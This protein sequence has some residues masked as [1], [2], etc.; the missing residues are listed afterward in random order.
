MKKEYVT[1]FPGRRDSYQVPLALHESGRL[2][3]FVTN[4]YDAGP[5]AR[6]IKTCGVSRLEQRYCA[7][8]PAHRVQPG[9]DLEIGARMLGKVM[10]PSRGA[11]IADDW[12]ARRG[13][14][15]A[16]ARG[17]SA[18]FY[19]FQAELGFRL[20]S[21]PA[22]RKILFH[23]HPHPGWEH[24][25][26][27]ADVAEWPDFAEHLRM[28]TRR[29]MAPRFSEHTCHAWQ[30]ADH[31]I[32]AS[33]C[34]QRSLIHVGCPADRITVV[35]YGR[36]TVERA[37]NLAAAPHEERPYF[38]WV[39]AGSL[40]KGLHHLCRAWTIS[41]CADQANLVVVARVVDPGMEKLLQAAG[42][43][44]IPGLPR[45]EL[46][47]YFGHAHAFVM[48]SLSEG[49]GQVY[50]E[51]LAHGCRVIGTK[52]TV[53]PDIEGAQPWISYVEPGEVE[54]LAECLQNSLRRGPLDAAEKASI[55]ASVAG[56]TWERFR[57]GVEA[58]LTRFD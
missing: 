4:A 1:A 23:F 16:N 33:S 24:P 36:E 25:I 50:L 31:V 27:A 34:T 29:G 55:Q 47:W 32:V 22:Q 12:L 28:S 8:L 43:R 20:L 57:T 21:G 17:A 58:V 11:V 15:A 54:M 10:E 56:F 2:V 42:I 14:A 6:A 26:L 52:N 7:G 48:P 37:G 18:L 13:A 38:L 51:A 35:P 49:F 30:V 39:G 40:R 19:E 53:L 44:W 5:L 45:A 9:F 3:K 46:N 41:G